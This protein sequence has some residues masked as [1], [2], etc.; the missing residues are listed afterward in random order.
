MERTFASICLDLWLLSQQPADEPTPS[1]HAY[2][3]AVA[4]AI[5][6]EGLRWVQQAGLHT[7]WACRSASGTRHEL[8][9]S[10]RGRGCAFLV[11]AKACEVSKGDLAGFEQKVTD[12]YF[13]RWRTVAS[14]AWSPIIATTEPASEATRR[15]ALHRALVVCDSE[16]LP[17]PVL[18]HHATLPASSARLPQVLCAELRR[19]APPALQT[20]QQRYV[21][22]PEHGCLRLEPCPYTT[23]ELDDLL[24]LQE[25]LSHEVID[26]YDR[27]RPGQL[28]LR[29][30]WL[31]RSLASSSRSPRRVA[32]PASRAG[33]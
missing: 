31:R 5:S 17:L 12:F 32:E 4:Q 13:A 1:G 15:L 22:D 26:R 33:R 24:F 2:Q 20:L 10:S 3:R 7:L 16:R 14:H 11:E 8:D 29:A 9:A 6:R 27:L 18:Y 30:A 23:T 19:L 25:E 28:D 21:P